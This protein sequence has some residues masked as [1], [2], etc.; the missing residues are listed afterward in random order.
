MFQKLEKSIGNF[1]KKKK[2]CF[3]FEKRHKF[4]E[5]KNY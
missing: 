1:Y 4:K 3:K 5:L 2:N